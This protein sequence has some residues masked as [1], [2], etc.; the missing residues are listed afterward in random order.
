MLF[1]KKYEKMREKE[2][3]FF[4]ERS[5]KNIVDLAENYCERGSRDEQIL[6]L[7]FLIDSLLDDICS[8]AVN[9]THCTTDG[10]SWYNIHTGEEIEKVRDF[11]LAAVYAIA[12]MRYEIIHKK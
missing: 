12:R 3:V 6:L 10:L 8:S 2:D 7:N 9:V 1:R 4:S 11:R 5:Y